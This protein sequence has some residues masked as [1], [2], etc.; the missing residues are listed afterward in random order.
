M[1]QD[2]K[3]KVEN[4]RWDLSD[5]YDSPDDPELT[6]DM[7][8]ALK[9]SESFRER[10]RGRI[11]DLDAAGL[12]DA[13]EEYEEIM[14]LVRRISGYAFLSWATNTGDPKYGKLR[15]KAQKFH[16]D[17]DQKITFFE[18]EWA[19]VPEEKLELIR[20]PELEDY[21][22]YLRQTRVFKPY[23]REES[24]ENIMTRLSMSGKEGWSRFFEEL[25]GDLTY[26]FEGEE[27]TQSELLS[28]MHSPDREKRKKAADVLTDVLKDNIQQL[29]YVFNMI[30]LDKQSKDEIRGYEHWLKRRNL[31]NQIEDDMVEALVDAV[32]S[33]FDVVSRYYTL[34]GD[35]LEVEQL[36]EYD[37]YAPIASE[38]TE[39]SWN[40]AKEIVLDAYRTFDDRFADIAGK[41]F[42]N[43]WIDAPPQ[44]GKRGGAFSAPLDVGTHPYVLL[45]Y[46]ADTKWMMTLAHELG[47]GVHQYLA[48]DQGQLHADTPLTTAE[49]ASTFGEMLVFDYYIEN[50]ADEETA[51]SMRMNKLAS[52]FAT[53]FRQI[54][55]NRFE[56][57]LHTARRESGE[58][59]TDQISEYWQNTQQRMFGDSLTLREGHKYWWS[60]VHH[61]IALPGYV[62]AYAFG[63]LLVWSMYNRFR[64]NP[65][66]F[67]ERYMDVLRAGGSDYPHKILEPMNVDLKDP[68]FWHNGLDLIDEFMTETEKKAGISGENAD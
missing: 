60:Y 56:D 50:R 57:K 40:E 47:H 37:R 34:L 17:I 62:Y 1:S 53:V 22:H 44:R 52:T 55:M 29:T 46:N 15:A 10:Y 24:E 42:E 27:L 63:E 18:I 43:N 31:N 16:S 2:I 5:L 67:S 25:L 30:L 8:K 23:K 35:E 28:K 9:K 36:Y 49:M 51:Y 68:E 6:G 26:P 45:N 41:F 58:L 32:T 13:L 19:K 11:A 3:K 33:R 20:E 54:C 7:E 4:V 12:A 64:E 61:F 21:D 14:I 59:S 48:K 38:K 65:D 66:G 39:V